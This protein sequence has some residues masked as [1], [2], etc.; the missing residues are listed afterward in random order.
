MFTHISNK[1]DKSNLFTAA[2]RNGKSR[3]NNNKIQTKLTV[4]QLNDKHEQVDRLI[5]DRQRERAEGKTVGLRPIGF[6]Y[7]TKGT[8]NAAMTRCD[9]DYT[10]RSSGGIRCVHT[11]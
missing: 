7:S 1:N 3:T 5:V 10:Q 11:P 9:V 4:C 2:Q 6:R 8:K